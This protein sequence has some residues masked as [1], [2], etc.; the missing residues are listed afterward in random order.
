MKES[1]HRSDQFIMINVV[2][3]ASAWSEDQIRV[4]MHGWWVSGVGGRELL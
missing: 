3:P 4:V 2:E 1:V